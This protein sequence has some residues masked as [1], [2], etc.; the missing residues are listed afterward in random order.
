LI[1]NGL[2]KK[3][4]IFL[5]YILRDLGTFGQVQAE[6]SQQQRNIGIG[7]DYRAQPHPNLHRALLGKT[8]PSKRPSVGGVPVRCVPSRTESSIR[9]FHHRSVCD[10]CEETYGYVFPSAEGKQGTLLQTM[11]FFSCGF[12]ASPLRIETLFYP[13]K[14]NVFR[15]KLRNLG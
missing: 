3:L 6:P 13:P 8:F 14:K 4:A 5:H 7:F 2:C 9:K 15:L 12:E 11:P 1:I 10:F